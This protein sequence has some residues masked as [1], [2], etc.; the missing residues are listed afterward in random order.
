MTYCMNVTYEPW[1][2]QITSQTGLFVV[3]TPIGHLGDMTIRGLVTLAN[4]DGI[5]SEDTRTTRQLLQFY[6]LSTPCYSYHAHNERHKLR[7]IILLLQKGKRLALVSD[8]GTPLV[9]DPGSL[10][11]K[12]CLAGGIPVHVISGASSVMHAWVASGSDYGS[13]Y[14][15]GF[16]PQRKQRHM[17]QSLSSIA[18]PIIFFVPPHDFI[19]F[20]NQASVHLG[21]RSVILLRELS[22]KFEQRVALPIDDMIVWASAQSVLGECVVIIEPPLSSVVSKKMIATTHMAQ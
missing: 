4:V 19:A 6:G 3:S 17:W 13:F 18:V 22:K 15:Q 21:A 14:F 16:I 10:L 20:L 9:A 2:A 11:V 5:L 12:T 1:V 8:R 7:G